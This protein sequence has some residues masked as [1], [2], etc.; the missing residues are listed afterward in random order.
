MIRTCSHAME[1]KER[2]AAMAM[3]ESP[4]RWPKVK[5]PTV[6]CTSRTRRLIINSETEEVIV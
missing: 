5:V 4:R 6:E 1:Q 3:R 2:L